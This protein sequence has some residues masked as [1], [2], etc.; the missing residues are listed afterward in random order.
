MCTANRQRDCFT[1]RLDLYDIPL[2][3]DGNSKALKYDFGFVDSTL[4]GWQTN[5]DDPTDGASIPKGLQ[6]I[7]G[8]P[9]DEMF[10]PAAVI[11][12]RYCDK[13]REHRVYPWKATHRMFYEALLATGLASAKARLMY[14]AV[15]T[16]G[17]RWTQ[18]EIDIGHVCRGNLTPLCQQ[19]IAGDG[20]GKVKDDPTPATL[21]D[22]KD[23]LK[24]YDV[25][26]VDKGKAIVFRKAIY[27]DP[28]VSSDLKSAQKILDEIFASPDAEGS[29]PDQQMDLIEKLSDTR[30]PAEAI[31]L[32]DEKPQP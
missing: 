14:Y 32:N 6:W 22:P 30:H 29:T 24:K 19:I 10:V 13:K 4:T 11:H 20:G 27:D 26:K 8:D 2:D 5:A 16:F 18:Q 1:G 23:L 28:G 31:L 25:S 3:T 15:Y 7:V 21:E 17:P 12:D 9:F